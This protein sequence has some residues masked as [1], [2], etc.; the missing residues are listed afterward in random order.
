M[1]ISNH[2]LPDWLQRALVAPSPV[3][4]TFPDAGYVLVDPNQCR[5]ASDIQNW[6]APSR[7]D[8]SAVQITPLPGA[9]AAQDDL[10][11][12]HLHW[13]VTL[14]GLQGRALAGYEFRFSLL[15]LNS[16]PCLTHLPEQTIPVVARICAF[17]ARRAA[18]ITSV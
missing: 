4:V 12:S 14:G 13:A 1:A 3:R 2:H 11:L 10:P 8:G 7:R 17:E 18:S 9:A 16:W 15:R 6:A 5:Y